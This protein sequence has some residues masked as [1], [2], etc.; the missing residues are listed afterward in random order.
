MLN[1]TRPIPVYNGESRWVGAA[2]EYAADPIALLTKL[3][4]QYPDIVHVNLGRRQLVITHNADYLQHILVTH[5]KNYA[6]PAAFRRVYTQAR[7]LSLF[8]SEGEYWRRQRRLFQPAF[9]RESIAHMDSLF[10]AETERAIRAWET[11]ADAQSGPFDLQAEIKAL[12]LNVVGRALFGVY[13]EG[14]Q[15]GSEGHQFRQAL[16]HTIT[17]M[18]RR[19]TA[20]VPVPPAIPT[21]ANRKFQRARDFVRRTLLRIITERRQQPAEAHHDLLQLLVHL[22]Y[23]DTGQ[24]MTDDQIIREAISFFFAGHET[25]AD[26]LAWTIYLLS[27]HPDL[28]ARV[29]AEVDA[30]LGGRT[31]T[32]SDLPNLP[33]TLQVIEESMRLFPAAWAISREPLTDDVLGDYTVRAGQII[34]LAIYNLHHHPRYWGEPEC[35]NPDRFSPEGR[36]QWPKHAYL[37]FGAG[38]RMCIGKP[39][40]LAEAHTALAHMIQRLAFQAPDGYIARPNAVFNMSIRDGLPVIVARR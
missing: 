3:L 20:M 16:D 25:T 9:H 39:F 19:I 5:Q 35:F 37:P 32:S 10:T 22:R 24:G 12:T 11:R 4:A 18:T 21:P 33:Y 13:M 23:E 31:P 40:G 17:W 34:Y 26:T 7:G 29:R 14:E 1:S 2:R 8:T 27:R 38:P 6:H 36:T 30:V 28:Q 15:A